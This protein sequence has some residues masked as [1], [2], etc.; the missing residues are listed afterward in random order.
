M[1]KSTHA[2]TVRPPARGRALPR[3]G[4]HNLQAQVT[5]HALLNYGQSHR[6]GDWTQRLPDIE[7]SAP[8][9]GRRLRYI[10][11]TVGLV[12]RWSPDC[13]SPNFSLKSQPGHYSILGLHC[14][15]SLTD[16]IDSF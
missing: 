13:P 11:L 1:N 5:T 14:I 6:L 15:I 2:G 8:K 7:I 9:S 12:N 16:S 4:P 3:D 10:G